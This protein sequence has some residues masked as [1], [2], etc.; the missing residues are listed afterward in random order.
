MLMQS[1]LITPTEAAKLIPP[2]RGKRVHASTIIRWG[3]AGRFKLYESNGYRV[4]CSEIM[5][6]FRVRISNG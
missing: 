2:R 3:K 5:H 1:D 6:K 4:S